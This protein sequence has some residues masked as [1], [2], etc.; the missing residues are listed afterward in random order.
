MPSIDPMLMT[1]RRLVD[2]PCLLQERDEEL[3]EVEDALHVEGQ[4]AL[5]RRLVVVDQGGAPGG[6]GVVDED[7]ESVHP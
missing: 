1:P 5:E 3:R 7:V 2:R 4:H 6:A